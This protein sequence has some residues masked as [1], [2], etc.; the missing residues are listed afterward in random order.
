M[1]PAT[2]RRRPFERSR[3]AA[4]PSLRISSG[5]ARRGLAGRAD[6]RPDRGRLRGD[7][8]PDR[9]G[10]EHPDSAGRPLPGVELRIGEPDEDGVG[11]IEV[12]S[13]ALFSGYL[14]DARDGR[15]AHRRRLAAN[16]RPRAP[17]RGRPADRRRPADRPHRPRRRE[18]RPFEI[19]SVLLDHP[20]IADAA[21]S[22]GRRGL[23]A[24]A[25]R[26]DRPPDR[27]A[28]P[29]D[30]A[31]TAFCRDRL[32]RFKVPAAFVRL[33]ALPRTADGKL[34]RAELRAILDPTRAS[35]RRPA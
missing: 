17:R 32:A 12:R 28:D 1:R 27:A 2:R 18:H 10:R 5:G 19:E 15:R 33:A 35:S 3:S 9:R 25:G 13:A 6:L 11:E 20:A 26:G 4:G 29:G 31:L 34:R 24:R 23:R 8:P 21:S 16:R 22:P 14:D 30:E 7:G